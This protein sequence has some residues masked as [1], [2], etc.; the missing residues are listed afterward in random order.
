MDTVLGYENK[1]FSKNMIYDICPLYDIRLLSILLWYV[2]TP[3]PK[4]VKSVVFN[5][6]FGTII[7]T[8]G[9]WTENIEKQLFKFS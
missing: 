8:T 2:L 1:G 5:K 9:I 6:C 3:F 4:V 7:T